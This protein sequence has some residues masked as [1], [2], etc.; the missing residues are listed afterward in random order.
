MIKKG[1]FGILALAL[2][3]SATVAFAENTGNASSTRSL[4]RLENRIQTRTENRENSS[5]THLD[6]SS[7]HPLLRDRENNGSTT[8]MVEA[9]CAKAAVTVRKTSLVATYATFTTALNSALSTREDA[10]KASFDQTTKSAR[11]DARKTARSNY[12]KSVKSAYGTL[13]SSE[14]S[15]LVTYTASIKACGGNNAEASSESSDG[16]ID[17]SISTKK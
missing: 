16:S 13:R 8:K 9:N 4:Q 5:T 11:E 12:K 1:I 7:T 17:S 3:L 14:K 10:V 6:A 15:A 2:V